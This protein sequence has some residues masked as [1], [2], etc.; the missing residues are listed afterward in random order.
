MEKYVALKA[1]IKMAFIM[2]M[3]MHFT[4]MNAQK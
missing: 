2:V 3:R 1:V 4:V